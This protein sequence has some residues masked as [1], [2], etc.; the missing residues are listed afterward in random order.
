MADHG[1][2][3]TGTC[4]PT[5]GRTDA[6][7]DDAHADPVTCQSP[8]VVS[9]TARICADSFIPA[10]SGRSRVVDGRPNPSLLSFRWW[11]PIPCSSY[12]FSFSF[13]LAVSSRHWP[14]VRR[15]S[16]LLPFANARQRARTIT[17]SFPR[18]IPL[19]RARTLPDAHRRPR[20]EGVKSIRRAS[21]PSTRPRARDV[22]ALR[23][24]RTELPLA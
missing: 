16:L 15:V 7:R 12:S 10:T 9:Y 11:S 6:P 19:R 17:L 24:R 18:P 13:S 3:R 1:S 8:F 14:V 23:P 5:D 20:R 21:A 4:C 2:P 22:S